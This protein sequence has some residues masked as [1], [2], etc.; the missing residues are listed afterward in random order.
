MKDLS[1]G[2]GASHERLNSAAWR[3]K[4]WQSAVPSIKKR[5]VL[6]YGLESFHQLSGEFFV[7]EPDGVPAHNVYVEL[8]FE[9]GVIGFITFLWIY[10]SILRTFVLRML[11]FRAG[12]V[13]SESVILFA[14]VIGYLFV[15]VSDNMLHYLAFNWYFWFFVGLA[16]QPVSPQFRPKPQA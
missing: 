14:Y 13:S 5:F 7:L 6:G 8:L 12:P 10:L 4:L 9:T 3:M 16:Q 15:C 11:R 2:T 1:E